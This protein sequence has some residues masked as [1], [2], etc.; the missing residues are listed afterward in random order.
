MEKFS[1]GRTK[2]GYYINH[3]LAPYFLETLMMELKES[4]KYV[5][6]FDESLNKKLQKG[7]MDI[8]IRY[9]DSDKNIAITRYMNS[10]FMGGAKAEQ[11]FD[12]F[13]EGTKNLDRKSLLQISSD[14][15]NVN[16]KFLDLYKNKRDLKELPRLSDIETYGLHTVHGSLKNGIKSSKIR[17]LEKH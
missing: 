3:G 8:L 4:P 10:Q 14:G 11:I 6:S 2:C 15:P 16:L 12:P 17:K 5:L 9:W 1:C 13:L 7:Q